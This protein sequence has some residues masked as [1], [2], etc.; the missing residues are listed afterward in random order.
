MANKI[1]GKAFVCVRP[2]LPKVHRST[3]AFLL[4]NIVCSNIICTGAG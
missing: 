4:T 3:A 1:G 2:F